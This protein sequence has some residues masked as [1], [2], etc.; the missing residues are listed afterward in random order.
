MTYIVS[1]NLTKQV[2]YP[3]KW[4]LFFIGSL[5]LFCIGCS[6]SR[7]QAA[8]SVKVIEPPP[9]VE[10]EELITPRSSADDLTPYP[11]DESALEVAIQ[12]SP[13]ELAEQERQQKRQEISQLFET[14]RSIMQKLDLAKMTTLSWETL[15]NK[16]LQKKR[17]FM[18][19]QIIFGLLHF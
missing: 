12:L 1:E 7:S 2:L 14:S 16:M 5:V 9:P 8:N 17:H 18:Y 4:K 6:S 11:G 10:E 15:K 3:S 13:E 19:L